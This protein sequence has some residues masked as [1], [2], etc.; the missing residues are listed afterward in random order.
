MAEEQSVRLTGNQLAQ[1]ANQER[2]KL[3]GINQRIESYQSFRNE[4]M[5]AKEALKE[6]SNTQKGGKILVN[7][8]AGVF[9]EA[10]ATENK[11]AI[12]AMAGSIFREKTSEN[13]IRDIDKK[14]AGMDKNI[15]DVA[16]QQQKTISRVNQLDQIMSA[17]MQQLRAAKTQKN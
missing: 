17:G 2:Q 6:L 12:S 10:N 4:L 9:I 3:A 7:L 14:I 16:E 15:A 13:L 8:G 1:L 5:G 11:K